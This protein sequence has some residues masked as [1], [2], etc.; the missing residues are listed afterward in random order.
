MHTS[1]VNCKYS[2]PVPVL[3]HPGGD[4][5]PAEKLLAKSRSVE[6][7]LETE[8]FLRYAARVPLIRPF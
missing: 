3:L 5:E 8:H 7:W 2:E 1:L 4:S 6:K